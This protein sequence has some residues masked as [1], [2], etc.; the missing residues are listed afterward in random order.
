ML[1][2]A[3]L[4]GLTADPLRRMFASTVAQVRGDRLVGDDKRILKNILKRVVEL[5]ETRNDIIHR[6]WYVGWAAAEDNDFSSV[7]GMKFK[8]TTQGVEFRGLHYTSQDF[9]NHSSQADDLT[10][11]IQ[12][13]DGCMMLDLPFSSNF[14]IDPDGTVRPPKDT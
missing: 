1:C 12:R 14:I 8:N 11:V 7:S 2:N 9:D 4:E 3:V 6:M 5:T 10:K 13:L